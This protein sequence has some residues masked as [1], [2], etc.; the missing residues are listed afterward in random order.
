MR[1]P[2]LAKPLPVFDRIALSAVK[3]ASVLLFY[4]GNKITEFVGNVVYRHPYKPPAFHAALYLGTIPYL[5][6]R[7]MLN[8]GGYKTLKDLDGELLSTR[9]VDVIELNMPDA[10][11]EAAKGIAAKDTSKLDKPIELPDYGWTDYLRFGFKFLKPSRKDFCSENC[12]EI[13][14]QV[15]VKSSHKKAV[16]TAPWTLLEFALA[17]PDRAHVFTLH[18]GDKFRT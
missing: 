9:R 4:G 1:S 12:V 8:V 11:R 13:L 3:P 16:D 10:A 7:L 2:S 18:V 5:G 17:N 14:E 15:G 6:D